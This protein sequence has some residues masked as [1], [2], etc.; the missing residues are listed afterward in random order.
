MWC[1]L[2]VNGRIHNVDA[3]RNASLLNVLRDDLQLTGTRFGCAHGKC[4]AC[5][6]LIDGRPL[7]SCLLGA[8]E[9]ADKQ[10]TTI[11]GIAD[12]EQLHPV[13]QAFVELDA[14]QCGYCTSGMV[15]SAVALLN[16]NA[17]PSEPEIRQALSANLCRC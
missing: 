13:Q 2:I 4:G 15:I 7:A 8:V 6:V 17:R 12:D 3:P 11:E 1:K 10:I 9:S 16:R 5:F 14:M